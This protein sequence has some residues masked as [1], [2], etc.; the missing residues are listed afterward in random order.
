MPENVEPASPEPCPRAVVV[1]GDALAELAAAIER[2]EPRPDWGDMPL[3]HCCPEALAL[4]TAVM[5]RRARE[6]DR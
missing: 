4:A 3:I 2:D 5:R 6:R 1:M